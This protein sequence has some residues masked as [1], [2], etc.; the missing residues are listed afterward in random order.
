MSLEEHQIEAFKKMVDKL[1]DET[2]EN[3]LRIL[4][5]AAERALHILDDSEKYSIKKLNE[6]LTKYMERAEVES[7]K[8]LAKI[9]SEAKMCLLRLKESLFEKVIMEA[10][11][12]ITKYCETD[13]Y[14]NDLIKNLKKTSNTIDLGVILMNNKDIERIG[15]KNLKSILGD[16]EIKPHKI[17]IGG[18]IAI[19]KDEKIFVD[20]TIEGIFDKEKMFLRSRI[21]SLLFR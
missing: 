8:E 1:F 19:S 12:M 6:S 11:S 14:I 3:V 7:K 15:M 5:E 17:E 18:F 9:E 21:A 13:E 4:N 16:C 20:K 10:K 2:K